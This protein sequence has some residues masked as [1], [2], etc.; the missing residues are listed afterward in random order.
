MYIYIYTYICIYIYIYTY[1]HIYIY[2][3][4]CI[5]V[6]IH[7]H[8]YMYVYIPP[9]DISVSRLHELP[10][11]AASPYNLFP[12]TIATQ[13]NKTCHF[14]YWFFISALCIRS[15][16]PPLVF[17]VHTYW[18]VIHTRKIILAQHICC[19]QL[20]NNQNKINSWHTN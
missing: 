5:D 8:V 13:F 6:Y 15:A 18:V 3:C 10:C 4:I 1:I 7:L 2:I 16:S 14:L 17:S 12:I 9:P 11:V 19:L 20:H